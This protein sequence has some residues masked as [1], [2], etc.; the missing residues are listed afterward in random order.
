MCKIPIHIDGLHSSL[1]EEGADARFVIYLAHSKQDMRHNANYV[2][3]L[4][5]R[6]T[7][8]GFISL[9]VLFHRF[10]PSVLIL[11]LK[12]FSNRKHLSLKT[13]QEVLQLNTQFFFWSKVWA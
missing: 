3:S 13:E 7:R 10:I 9:S 11:I 5:K 1:S 8:L 2:F 6:A 12:T 4:S